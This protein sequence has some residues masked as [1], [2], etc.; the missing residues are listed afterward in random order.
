MQLKYERKTTRQSWP[1]QNMQNAVREVIERRLGYLET[2]KCYQVPQTILEAKVNKV[3]EGMSVEEACEKGISSPKNNM[4][5]EHVEYIILIE[6]R[7]F[8]VSLK[9]LRSLGFEHSIKIISEKISIKMRNYPGKLGFMILGTKPLTEI[10]NTQGCIFGMWNGFQP[11]YDN[12]IFTPERISNVD[13]TGVSTVPNKKFKVLPLRGK[14]QVGA[15]TSAERGTLVTAEVCMSASGML[16]PVMF[17][18][19]RKTN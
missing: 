13:E 12:H 9:D 8:R 1:E 10:A 7:L 3:R 15:L 14:K 6:N 11:K 2:S 5:E 4:H 17:V 16:M 18:F 19:P